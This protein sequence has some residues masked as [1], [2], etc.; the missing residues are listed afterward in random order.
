MNKAELAAR[1]ATQ[2]SLSEVGADVAVNAVFSTIA[3]TLVGGETVTI[4]RFGTFSTKSRPARQGRKPAHGR[5]H[6]QR[7]LEP[8]AFKAGETLRDAVN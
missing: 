2:T 8:P 3:D 5:K 6:R 1:V 4:A 7:R